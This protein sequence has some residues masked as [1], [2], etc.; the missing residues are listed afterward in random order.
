MKR[1]PEAMRRSLP[2]AL[3][4]AAAVA[5]S[6]CTSV[7]FN[8]ITNAPEYPPFTGEVQVIESLPAADRFV[9]L[10]TVVARGGDAA[11]GAGLTKDLQKEAARNGANAI[12]L[13]SP[14][15][16]GTSAAGKELRLAAWA[17][18]IER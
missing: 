10:G 16:E 1:S 5:L 18:R 6:A 11:T 2:A 14:P 9:R 12:M 8:R 17:F 3:L 15:R 13:Q 4:A 7:Q